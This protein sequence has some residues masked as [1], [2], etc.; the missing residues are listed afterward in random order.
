MKL[1]LVLIGLILVATLYGWRLHLD[2]IGTK[3]P[4]VT[5]SAKKNVVGNWHPADLLD[6][7]S[8]EREHKQRLAQRQAK[9]T[10][11]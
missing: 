4:L 8:G 2:A 3:R 6:R 9:V 11:E 1:A 5:Y 7:F 10:A